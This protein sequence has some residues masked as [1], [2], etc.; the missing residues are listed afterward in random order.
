MDSAAEQTHQF[1]SAT[2]DFKCPSSEPSTEADPDESTTEETS[3]D[4]EVAHAA[5]TS[6]TSSS[7]SSSAAFRPEPIGV[8]DWGSWAQPTC[9]FAQKL[10]QKRPLA[11]PRVNSLGRVLKRRRPQSM[12]DILE[13]PMSAF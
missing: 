13:L 1:A 2:E 7:S 4:D 6:T 3:E 5:E 9:P 12:S 10:Q 8:F 11:S